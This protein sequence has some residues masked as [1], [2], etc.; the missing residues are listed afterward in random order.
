MKLAQNLSNSS[1]KSEQSDSSSSHFYST[2][3][4]LWSLCPSLLPDPIESAAKRRRFE[5]VE[6][7]HHIEETQAQRA[8]TS[9][10][11][12]SHISPVFEAM[13]RAS[14]SKHDAADERFQVKVKVIL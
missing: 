7:N 3:G 12:I 2:G 1:R 11:F 5:S 8:E 13:E 4:A 9:S 10:A 14:E 6:S